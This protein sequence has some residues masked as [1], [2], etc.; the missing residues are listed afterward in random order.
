[1]GTW[2][3]KRDEAIGTAASEGRDGDQ[4]DVNLRSTKKKVLNL[5]Y[6]TT[7]PKRWG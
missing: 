5:G 6:L 4:N 3:N 7:L 1:V 2:R